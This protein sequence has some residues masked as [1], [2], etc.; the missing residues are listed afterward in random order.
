VTR[1]AE[2]FDA[3][4]AAL[5]EAQRLST[6][7]YRWNTRFRLWLHPNDP[8][9][10]AR[11]ARLNARQHAARAAHEDSAWVL[12]RLWHRLSLQLAPGVLEYRAQLA[13]W[14]QETLPYEVLQ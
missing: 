1:F 10:E 11:A 7:E 8:D 9:I 2:A 12:D 3:E 14:R 4:R 6:L 13:A 5:K